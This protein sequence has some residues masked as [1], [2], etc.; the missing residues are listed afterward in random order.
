MGLDL[1]I[2]VRGNVSP[3]QIEIAQEWFTE[4]N[5][6]VH[7]SPD[8]WAGGLSIWTG[9]RYYGPTYER[10]D[11]PK[12]Y[13]LIRAVRHLFPECEIVYGDENMQASDPVTTDDDLEAIW[14]HYLGLDGNEYQ[15]YMTERFGPP[16]EKPI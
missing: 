10:G 6:E 13:G 15:R 7:F 3:E 9:D 12:I 1:M 5:I 11:W 8:S 4:R 16:I 14:Q 2:V